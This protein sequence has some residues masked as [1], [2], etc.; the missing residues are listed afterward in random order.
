MESAHRIELVAA[1]QPGAERA[2]VCEILTLCDIKLGVSQ[3][4]PNR[5]FVHD[6]CAGDVLVRVSLR[7]TSPGFADDQHDLAFVIELVRFWRVQY[8]LLVTDQR[9]AAAHEHARVLGQGAAVLVLRIPV[10]VVHADADDL[11]RV[12]DHR[13]K[14]EA[15]QRKIEAAFSGHRRQPI[16]RL[17][18][19]RGAQVGDPR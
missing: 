1:D 13:Q 9:F 14:F 11:F 15:V 2:R 4:V 17:F 10:R 12:R 6:R 8:R 7:N 18:T 16:E 5:T 3:P 19:N